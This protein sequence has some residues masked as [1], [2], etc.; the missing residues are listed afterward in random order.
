MAKNGGMTISEDQFA[1]ALTKMVKDPFDLIDGELDDVI[2]KACQKGRRD[3]TKYATALQL[4]DHG[5]KTT[6]SR[7]LEGFA[8]TTK[9]KKAGVF[10]EI[11]QKN[12]P[13]LVHLIEKGHQIVRH[14]VVMGKTTPRPHIKDAAE[15]TFKYTEKKISELV[16]RA[17]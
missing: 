9:R 5:S 10:G 14:G 15:D 6:W 11:G 12:V 2:S 16:D 8:S 7:Y 3:C 4:R 1:V 13:G 17:L